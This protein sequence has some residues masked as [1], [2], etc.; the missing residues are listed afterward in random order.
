MLAIEK[1]FYDFSSKIPEVREE[2]FWKRL[3]ILQMNSQE[4][5]ME[6]YRIIY[7]WKI[8]ENYA[9]NCGVELAPEN[10]RLGRKCKIPKLK[11]NGRCAIQT[12]REN[13]FQING[14]RLFNCLPKKLREIRKHQDEFK[15]EL[16]LFL[17]KIPDEPRMNSLAPTAV[18]RVTARQSS[19]LLA[20]IQDT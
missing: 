16:D 3:Q 18:C 9:P 10:F 5:R 7:M 6:R 11:P 19:S 8:L 13:S 17:S 15:F 14:A 20:W 2:I 1:S 4:R 12:L